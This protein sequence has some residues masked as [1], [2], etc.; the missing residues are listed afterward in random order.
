MEIIMMI[1]DIVQHFREVIYIG[2]FVFTLISIIIT[3]TG[4]INER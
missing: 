1:G 3:I 4:A 2:L